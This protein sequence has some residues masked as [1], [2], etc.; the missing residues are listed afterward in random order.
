M[1]L[2]E[3]N[4]VVLSYFSV[5]YVILEIR[6]FGRTGDVTALRA[7]FKAKTLSGSNDVFLTKNCPSATASKRLS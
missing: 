7:S 1:T 4:M 6:L 5:Q 3:E 2:S